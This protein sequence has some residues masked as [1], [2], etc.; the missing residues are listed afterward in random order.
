MANSG[1]SVPESGVATFPQSCGQAPDWRLGAALVT[2]GRRQVKKRQG[3]VEAC[4][5]PAARYAWQLPAA[6]SG[7][8]HHWSCRY[9][10]ARPSYT[11]LP[12]ST[13]RAI[14]S[15]SARK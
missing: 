13:S 10:E 9:A 14:V 15:K 1:S 5:R 8:F 6:A 12:A 3:G 7:F 2:C 11:R 4:T